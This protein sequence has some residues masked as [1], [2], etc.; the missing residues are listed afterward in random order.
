MLA[1]AEH[2]PDAWA[3]AVCVGKDFACAVER[4]LQSMIAEQ[5]RREIIRAA[6]AGQGGVITVE[7]LDE[8]L[9]VANAF[10]PEHLLLA[11][12]AKQLVDRVRNA[13]TVFVGETASVSFGD[14]ISGANHVLPTGG[15][16]RAYSGLSVLDFIRWT[17]CQRID[18]AAATSL[19]S[20]TATFARAEGLPGHAAAAAQWRVA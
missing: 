8:A 15:L 12:G 11:G 14:Y 16:A 4:E 20:D 7:S 10:A 9:A 13:G 18:R 6:L 3:V 2:D 1:Q 5:A 19:S 17:T